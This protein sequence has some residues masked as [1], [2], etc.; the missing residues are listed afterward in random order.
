MTTNESK[1]KYIVMLAFPEFSTIAATMLDT[2]HDVA[3]DIDDA[4]SAGA[5]ELPAVSTTHH[6][7]F[8]DGVKYDLFVTVVVEA[9][10]VNAYSERQFESVRDEILSAAF[11]NWDMA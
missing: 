1:S 9:P 10:L 5:Y 2:L 8:A 3:Q 11:N 4:F 7:L 6:K